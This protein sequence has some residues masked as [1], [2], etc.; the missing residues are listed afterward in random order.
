MFV[1]TCV[2]IL[3][4][5]PSLIPP[6]YFFILLSSITTHTHTL[7]AFSV[8]IALL[9]NIVL[10]CLLSLSFFINSMNLFSWALKNILFRL[11][12]LFFCMNVFIFGR[13]K[14]STFAQFLLVILLGA[15]L[16]FLTCIFSC[17]FSNASY[18]L[19][20]QISSIDWLKWYLCGKLW[21]AL[22]AW[23]SKSYISAL[24][25]RGYTPSLLG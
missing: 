1:Y 15:Y 2:S 23:V 21:R 5:F 10:Y 4:L 20:P 9:L 6:T 16:I 25:K 8:Y 24:I 19:S 17:I 14:I 7:K 13:N 3:L 22:M 12:Y 18:Q 11:E